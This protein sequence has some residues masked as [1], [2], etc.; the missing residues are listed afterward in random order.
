MDTFWDFFWIMFVSFMFFAYLLVLFQ[1]IGDLFA[2]R[3]LGGW[4]KGAW[5]VLL[6]F[7]PLLGSLIYLIANGSDM[8]RR[9]TEAVVAAR[10]E[11]EV[12]IQ[13]VAGGGTSPT[14][15]I[16]RAQ[17]LLRDGAI[18]QTE[19][20]HLKQAALA[21]AGGGAAQGPAAG[22]PESELRPI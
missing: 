18:D 10:E 2:D 8:T 19:F 15:E 12:Y 21:K 5:I 6:V 20:A 13:R 1:I 14:E 9:R 22:T 17:A 3:D 7:L 11:T 16:S 4:G